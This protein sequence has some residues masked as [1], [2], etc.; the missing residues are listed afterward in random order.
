MGIALGALKWA[1]GKDQSKY[2]T[3]FASCPCTRSAEV[4]F[5]RRVVWSENL[6]CTRLRKDVV[7]Q[8]QALKI[9]V[10]NTLNC[11]RRMSYV[12]HRVQI[13]TIYKARCRLIDADELQYVRSPCTRSIRSDCTRLAIWH[14]ISCA[15]LNLESSSYLLCYLKQLYST[16]YQQKKKTIQFHSGMLRAWEPR[17]KSSGSFSIF[18]STRSSMQNFFVCRW[19]RLM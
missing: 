19:N 11:C 14:D 18:K 15:V 8:L 5:A 6:N 2:C 7:F 3:K 1:G 12:N 13:K 9:K 17:Y 10:W 4:Y 16:R